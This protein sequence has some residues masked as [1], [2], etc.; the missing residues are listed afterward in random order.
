M[1]HLSR[2]EKMPTCFG[3]LAKTISLDSLSV[4]N[5]NYFQ[6]GFYSVQFRNFNISI[7]MEIINY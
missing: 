1:V 5:F 7:I 2:G 6:E 3:G 4:K